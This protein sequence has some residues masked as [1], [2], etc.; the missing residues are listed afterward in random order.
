[1]ANRV[2]RRSCF[3]LLH[4]KLILAAATA[5]AATINSVQSGNWS[6]PTTWDAG[7]PGAADDVTIQTGHTIGFDVGAT[8]VNS[9]S[10]QANT[11]LKSVSG[12]D[13]APGMPGG[14]AAPISIVATSDI[15]IAGTIT[16]GNGGNGGLLSVTAPEN[17]DALANGGAGGT[18]GDITLVSQSGDIALSAT[19][20]IILGDGGNG[21]G[22]T[23]VGG[24]GSMGSSGGNA[25]AHG[26]VGGTAASLTLTCTQG[27]MAIPTISG[28]I[29]GSN[30]GRGGDSTAT[31]G[32]GGGSADPGGST[33]AGGGHGGPSGDMS[34]EGNTINGS[35]SVADP[36]QFLRSILAGGTGGEPGSDTT[37]P[38]SNGTGVSDP[39]QQV[40]W[41]TGGGQGASDTRGPTNGA[42][43]YLNPTDGASATATGRP[44]CGT[45]KGGNAVAIGGTGGESTL[46]GFKFSGANLGTAL[47]DNITNGGDATAI[48]GPAGSVGGNGGDATAKA[49]N[50]GAYPGATGAITCG[51]GGNAAAT[52][53]NG[54]N[55]TS[56]CTPPQQGQDGGDGGSVTA[57]G[58]ISNNFAIVAS[59]V[60]GFAE[61]HPGN[62]AN[63]GDGEPPGFKGMQGSRTVAAGTGNPNGAE[64]DFP[65]SDGVPGNPCCGNGVLDPG[66]DCDPPADD[67]CPGECQP[68]CRCPPPP[69]VCGDCEN[70]C[71]ND[72][73]CGFVGQLCS[74]GGAQGVCTD[75]G[76][77]PDEGAC[78]R[79]IP[80]ISQW[81][82]V[83]LTL[84]VMTAG[85]IFLGRHR[86]TSS[87]P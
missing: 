80:T 43:A 86:A 3:V 76:I 58:G 23:S 10:M 66:E 12:S 15:T 73:V 78:C 16:S 41:N 45:G 14:D 87:I 20:R 4:I 75:T 36:Q 27:D 60:G 57:T 46:F 71:I 6:E 50:A 85:T 68:E 83:I 70:D 48:G 61:T 13:G 25:E 17:A 55:G 19:G 9:L 84:L 26:G 8:Q 65:A 53:G 39:F 37:L 47:A 44:G 82:L 81:G 34:F 24:D 74:S 40:C 32:T 63:G 22:A 62:G 31:G 33:T 52:G 67:A 29:S 1:M 11:L 79:C 18:G 54:A 77:C 30:G 7:V 64:L 35:T 59:C 38:G 49:G 42:P 28:I 72:P 56:C 5:N 21:G 2:D 69:Q 51:F